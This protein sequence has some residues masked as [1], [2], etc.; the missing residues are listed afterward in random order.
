MTEIHPQ[1]AQRM[2][3]LLRAQAQ[4]HLEQA[5]GCYRRRDK[6]RARYNRIRAAA[7]CWASG[8]IARGQR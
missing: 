8:V 2:R 5:E 6:G 4:R 3:D 1:C 7:L